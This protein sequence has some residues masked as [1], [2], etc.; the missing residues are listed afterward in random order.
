MRPRRHWFNEYASSKLPLDRPVPDT[1]TAE[2]KEQEHSIEGL[3]KTSIIMCFVDEAW[4]TLLRSIVSI[5]NRTPHELI[6][7][8]ILV[9]FAAA[10]SPGVR[11][12][13]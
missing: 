4:S 8:I 11:A 2:C 6:H 7:E 9:R 12:A 5:I 3:P 13:R 10:A 1:R